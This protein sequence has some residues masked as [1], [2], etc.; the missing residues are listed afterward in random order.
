MAFE[1]PHMCVCVYI[2]N[3]IVLGLP[4]VLEFSCRAYHRCREGGGLSSSRAIG[5]VAG[6]KRPEA[7]KAESSLSLGLK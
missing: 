2:Y 7:R 3:M 6:E 1:G 4:G 5:R